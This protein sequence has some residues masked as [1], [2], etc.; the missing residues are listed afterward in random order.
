MSVGGR[1]F[2]AFSGGVLI[3][4]ASKLTGVHE[5]GRPYGRGTARAVG[6]VFVIAMFAAGFLFAAMFGGFGHDGSL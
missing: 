3:E 6:W 4:F 1:L 5:R 2:T